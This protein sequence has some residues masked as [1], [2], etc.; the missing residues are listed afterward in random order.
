MY[1]YK[2]ILSYDKTI[3]RFNSAHPS[4]SPIGCGIKQP[5]LV[6]DLSFV[7]KEGEHLM[8]TGSNGAGKNSVAMVLA[9][10]W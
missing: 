4:A 6:K 3:P 5:P 8:I 9:G 1:E 7:L 2:D 10:L